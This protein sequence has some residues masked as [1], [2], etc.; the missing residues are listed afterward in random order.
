[1]VQAGLH[2]YARSVALAAAQEGA[3]AA[4]VQ[5]ATAAAGSQAASAFVDTAGAEL[6]VGPQVIASRTAQTATV[7]VTGTSISLVP[8]YDGFPIRQ[9]A[10][11]PVEEVS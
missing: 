8:G 7:V 6:L 3:R 10:S 5:G 2:Y 11:V 1:V 4:A 9:Q